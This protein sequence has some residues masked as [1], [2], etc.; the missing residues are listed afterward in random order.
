MAQF[1]KCQCNP[2]YIR[3]KYVYNTGRFL[4]SRCIINTQL[5]Q[6]YKT[7]KLA[8]NEN[9]NSKKCQSSGG[10]KDGPRGGAPTLRRILFVLC[11]FWQH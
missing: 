6:N 5:M 10:P 9:V 11:K 7:N 2:G 8:N 1:G 3:L 4:L